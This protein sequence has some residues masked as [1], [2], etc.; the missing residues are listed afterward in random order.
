VSDFP[1]PTCSLPPAAEGPGVTAALPKEET[2]AALA[3]FKGCSG[4]INL[5]RHNGT[6]GFG[7]G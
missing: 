4:Q 6:F 5:R 2:A 3:G 7:S 1:F